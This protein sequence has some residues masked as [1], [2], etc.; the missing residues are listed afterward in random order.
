M[1]KAIKDYGK[2]KKKLGK[3]EGISIWKKSRYYQNI[4]QATSTKTRKPIKQYFRYYPI[5]QSGTA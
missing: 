3:E 4:N 1:C 2:Q 5:M